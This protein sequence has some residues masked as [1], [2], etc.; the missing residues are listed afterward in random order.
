MTTTDSR[1]DLRGVSADK[2]DVHNA[3]KGRST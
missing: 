2:T 3:I 1:Y